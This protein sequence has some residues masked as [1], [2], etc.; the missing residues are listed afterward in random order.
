[1]VLSLP[2][3]LDAKKLTQLPSPDVAPRQLNIPKITLLDLF[4]TRTSHLL[5]FRKCPLPSKC[6]RSP[7]KK[8]P[9]RIDFHPQKVRR[10]NRKRI[11]RVILPMLLFDESSCSEGLLRSCKNQALPMRSEVHIK[12][13]QPRAF[14]MFLSKHDRKSFFVPSRSVL[15]QRPWTLTPER[16]IKPRDGAQYKGAKDLNDLVKLGFSGILASP[17]QEGCIRDFLEARSLFP[18]DDKRRQ[19]IEKEATE[20]KPRMTFTR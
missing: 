1:M 9:F 12:V 19:R 5:R 13:E 8:Q 16:D 14:C 18:G 3:I 17:K 10:T 4:P 2:R 11:E 7:L 6:Y 20:F 15:Q